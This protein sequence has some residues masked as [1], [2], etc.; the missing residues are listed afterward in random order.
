M[1][2]SRDFHNKILERLYYHTVIDKKIAPKKN[3]GRRI[4]LFGVPEHLNYGDIAIFVAEMRF[5]KTE[6]PEFEVVTIPE[7]FVPQKIFTVKEFIDDN[8]IIALH[9]GGNFGDVWPYPDML[10]QDVIRAFGGKYRIISFPQSV[11]YS[12]LNWVNRIQETLKDCVDISMFARDRVSFDIMKKIFPSNVKCFLIPDIVMSLDR[13]ST[14]IR[15]NVLFL[16]RRDREKL[17][18]SSYSGIQKYVGDKYKYRISDTVDDTWHRIDEKSADKRVSKKLM[19]LQKSKL[20]ITDRLHGLIFSYITGTPV[21]VFDNNNHKIRNLY[22]TWFKGRS[23]LIC[24]VDDQTTKEVSGFIDDA[25]NGTIK[26]DKIKFN[27]VSLK[28]EFIR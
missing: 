10:R 21:V 15:N 6:L 26:V 20:V 3:A 12:D 18:D 11:S 22:D 5:L 19:E 17:R 9:G 8:D 14:L 28:H 25:M 1:K 13:R 2:L 24:F 27:Y 7:R 16:M 4:Y 23:N